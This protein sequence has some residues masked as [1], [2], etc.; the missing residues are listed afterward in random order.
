[1]VLLDEDVQHVGRGHCL[2]D[3]DGFGGAIGAK[4]FDE[5][6]LHVGLFQLLQG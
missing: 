3:E 2:V 4:D 5:E 6:L 1:M